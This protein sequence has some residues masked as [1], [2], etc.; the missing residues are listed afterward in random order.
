[1][2]QYLYLMIVLVG[3]LMLAIN[4]F[5]ENANKY[6]QRLTEQFEKVRTK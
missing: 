6:E 5:V 2:K 1:M 3:C 4:L